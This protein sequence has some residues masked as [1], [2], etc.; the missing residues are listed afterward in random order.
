[1]RSRGLVVAIAV[2]LAVL[3]AAGVIVYTNSLEKTIT[4]EQTTE[5]VV[6]TQGID[7]NTPLGPLVDAG[8]FDLIRVPNEAVVPGA[9]TV[10]EDLR[11]DTTSLP[12][13]PN[14]QIPVDR[15]AAGQS[16]DPL[17]IDEGNV[18]LGLSIGGPQSVNGYINQGAHIVVYA[19]FAKGTPVTQVELNEMLSPQQLDAFY[20]S[21]VGEGV[22][23]PANQP[24]LFL[25]F[26]FTVT[27][28]KSVE[29]LAVQNPP[30]DQ[31]SGRKSEGSTLLALN[32]TPEDASSL[33][34]ATDHS[35]LY[36]GLLPPKSDEGYDTEATV[37]VPLTKVLGVVK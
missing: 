33:V 32:L 3:A 9:V 4:T 37:G 5:V 24:I 25:P 34:F 27:L 2:V 28:I 11:D 16:A 31:A 19:T 8:V 17:G 15:L 14:E 23:N 22:T 6:S 29:V 7:A 36:M 35:Q 20:S 10:I 13:L 18:G 26:D 1:M 21:L 12:I 30:I